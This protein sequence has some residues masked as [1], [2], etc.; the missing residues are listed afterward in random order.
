VINLSQFGG[1]ATGNFTPD[2]QMPGIPGVNFSDDGIDAEIL[3]FIE[4]P[5]GWVTMGVNSDDSFRSEA[6]YLNVPADRMLLGQRD[7]TTG[8]T[9]FLIYVQNAGIYPVRTIWQEGA[10]GANIEIYTV[11]GDGTKVLVNDTDN[12]GLKSYRAG[13]VPNK[14]TAF[15]LAITLTGATVQITWTEPG[16]VLQQSDNL[17]TWS[18]VAGASSPYRPATAGTPVK[19]YRLKK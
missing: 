14:P 16:V 2:D 5:A 17:T 3:T 11:K 13:V 12:G 9:S 19:F 10:G 1:D 6:G 15:S 8:D 18:T 4:F 7:G